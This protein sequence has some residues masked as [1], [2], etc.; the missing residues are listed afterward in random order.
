M[1]LSELLHSRVLDAD[2]RD[3]GHVHDVRLVQDGPVL[4]GFGHALRVQGLVVG[5][6]SL[7]VRLGYHRHGVRG[8]ALVKWPALRLERRAR[9]VA[10]ADVDQW[11]G[12]VV[13]LRAR[14]DDLP[15]LTDVGAS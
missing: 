10:W 9:Y 5:A 12:D 1:R 3:I 11:D 4:E 13:R 14:A 8:P 15:R 2:G 7:G 6:G